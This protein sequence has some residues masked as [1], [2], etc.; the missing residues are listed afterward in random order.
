[1]PWRQSDDQSPHLTGRHLRQFV[2]HRFKVPVGL[3]GNAGPH[4]A[5]GKLG[6]R[7]QVIG[8]Q[9]LKNDLRRIIGEVLEASLHGGQSWF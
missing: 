8:K 1:V 6:K 3:E 7:G 5:K 9:G 4:H 2:G